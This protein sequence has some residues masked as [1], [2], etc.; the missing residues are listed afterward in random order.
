M[1]LGRINETRNNVRRN[2]VARRNT[3]LGHLEM[4]RKEEEK[5]A[6]E[7]VNRIFNTV[8]VWRWE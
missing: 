1:R 8:P 3:I 6:T 4:E 2:E 7:F 5:K